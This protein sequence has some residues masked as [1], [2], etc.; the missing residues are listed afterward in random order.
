MAPVAPKSILKPQKLSP[1]HPPPREV[2]MFTPASDDKQYAVPFHGNNK[3]A[4]VHFNVGHAR[5]NTTP[6]PQAK[7]IRFAEDTVFI[8]PKDIRR[9]N[10]YRRKSRHYKPGKHA[11]P[12]EGYEDTSHFRSPIYDYEEQPANPAEA[13]PLGPVRWFR[14]LRDLWRPIFE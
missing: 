1:K 5:R 11:P 2:P 9:S 7:R 14:R 8:D 10:A 12:P 3:G 13:R 6:A 4:R